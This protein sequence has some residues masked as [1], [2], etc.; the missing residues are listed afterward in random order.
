M[1]QFKDF[2]Y[3]EKLIGKKACVKN[4]LFAFRFGII[5]KN[6]MVTPY[7]IRFEDGNATG[8]T[9]ESDVIRMKKP[10]K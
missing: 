5:E 3:N 9:K 4:G 10:N 1:T 2:E 6:D 7:V 8:F